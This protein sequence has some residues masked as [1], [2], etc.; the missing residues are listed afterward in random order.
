MNNI[1]IKN[2]PV[3]YRR[4]MWLSIESF[5]FPSNPLP[6]TPSYT[7]FLSLS[8]IDVYSLSTLDSFF[9]LCGALFYE[10]WTFVLFFSYCGLCLHEKLEKKNWYEFENYVPDIMYNCIPPFLL[11]F[12]SLFLPSILL[13]FVSFVVCLFLFKLLHFFLFHAFEIR[14]DNL[15]VSW[16]ITM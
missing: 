8:L 2:I 9:L 10:L 16:Y 5:P 7:F 15:Q 4:L 13:S 14:G 3:V 1:F 11:S 6:H 12:F